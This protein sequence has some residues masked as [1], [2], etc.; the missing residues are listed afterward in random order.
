[1]AIKTSK[2]ISS[3]VFLA[4]SQI[5]DRTFKKNFWRPFPRKAVGL[6]MMFSNEKLT[7]KFFTK[8]MSLILN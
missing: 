5:Y 7:M 4:V 2:N 6:Q 8:I 1:M 3:F